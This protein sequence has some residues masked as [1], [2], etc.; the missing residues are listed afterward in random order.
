MGER[1]SRCENQQNAMYLCSYERARVACKLKPPVPF[2]ILY[3]PHDTIAMPI[4]GPN[5]DWCQGS[6]QLE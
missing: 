2:T 4:E 5:L 6:S 1:Y 3:L